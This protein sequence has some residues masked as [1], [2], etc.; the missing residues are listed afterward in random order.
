MIW[1]AFS[2]LR[3]KSLQWKKKTDSDVISHLSKTIMEHILDFF[4]GPNHVADCS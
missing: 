4:R 1:A 3:P 2:D